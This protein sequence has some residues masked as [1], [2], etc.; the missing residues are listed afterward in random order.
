MSIRYHPLLV[1]AEEMARPS[2]TDFLLDAN[3]YKVAF[4]VFGTNDEGK[5]TSMSLWRRQRP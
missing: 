4:P 5:L 1:V 3:E 2:F